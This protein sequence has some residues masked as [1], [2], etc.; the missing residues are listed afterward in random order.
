MVF[1]TSMIVSC[2]RAPVKSV[3]S[4]QLMRRD[5]LY[6][7]TEW[8]FSGRIALS[9]TKESLSAT[10]NWQHSEGLDN[11]ELSGP[12]GQGRMIITL[13]ENRMVVDS[14]D[15]VQEYEGEVDDLVS[16]Q[17]GMETPVTALKYWVIGLVSPDKEYTLLDGG[18]FQSGW[19]VKYLQM[20]L[21]AG[22][23]LPRKIRIEEGGSRLKLVI[24]DWDL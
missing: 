8:R 15:Q 1:F 20:Q 17:L 21:K 11:I 2:S 19:K 9:N 24:I 12:F 5:Y 18:F 16:Q 14:G 10:I 6:D 7:Q 4:F 13:S 3:D 23:Q 22:H